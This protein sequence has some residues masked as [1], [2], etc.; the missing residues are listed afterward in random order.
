MRVLTLLSSLIAF[1][2]VACSGATAPEGPVDDHDVGIENDTDDE[3]ETAPLWEGLV[4][5]EIA[6]VGEPEDWFELYNGGEEAIELTGYFFTD[7]KDGKPQRGSFPHQTVI[8]PSAYLLFYMD[9]DWPGFKLS[10]DEELA[11][12][13]PDGELVD[14]VD[15]EE[16]QSPEGKSF[17][18]I[19][20]GT[21]P[22]MTLDTPTPGGPNVANSEVA[23]C[24]NDV[25]EGDELCD[26]SDLNGISC[27][28]LGFIGGTVTC[29]PDCKAFD[30][31]Q[32]E[33]A[34][35]IIVI[36][37]VTSRGDD[38][39][40]F[41][42]LGTTAVDLTGWYFTDDEPEKPGHTYTF[43][44]GTILEP[45]GFLVRVKGVH[46]EFGLGSADHVALYN[47][48]GELVDFI[49]WTE[50]ADPSLC[51]LPDGIGEFQICSEQTFGAPNVE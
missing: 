24:G 36:N 42:N 37:E 48:E 19:P 12:F 7:D 50:H 4:I 28:G 45:A 38:E 39:V 16:G 33:T 27:E 15:W 22:F 1:S 2:F 31:T 11:L 32:C 8:E 51:R 18:R 46:H 44:D 41:Y 6:A 17:G 40:E 21:G 9:D 47:S 35:D 20:D 5:N 26:G 25:A 49:A 14:F 43:E 30:I 34:E 13:A 29:S 23:E 3:L 10:R